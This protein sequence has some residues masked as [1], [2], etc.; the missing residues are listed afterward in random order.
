MYFTNIE[1]GYKLAV[2]PKLFVPRCYGHC[3][4]KI[5]QMFPGSYIPCRFIELFPSSDT[6]QPFLPVVVSRTSRTTDEN[7]SSYIG[8]YR[9]AFCVVSHIFHALRFPPYFSCERT[10]RKNERFLNSKLQ[11]G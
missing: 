8:L 9:L 11:F 3:F 6:L 10:F 2:V 4:E 5:S 1:L 7:S